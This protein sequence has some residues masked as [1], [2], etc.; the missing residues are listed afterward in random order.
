MPSSSRSAWRVSRST[1]GECDAL[2]ST[3]HPSGSVAWVDGGEKLRRKWCSTVYALAASDD[4]RTTDVPHDLPPRHR[5][6]AWGCHTGGASL[7]RVSSIDP[8]RVHGRRRLLRHLRLS[9][10]QRHRFE[11]RCAKFFIRGFL[12]ETCPSNLSGALGRPPDVLRRRVV[13]AP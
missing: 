1:T 5:W 6:A 7:P 8:R 11:P 4:G 9:H 3:P 2:D 10:L 12:R 13:R